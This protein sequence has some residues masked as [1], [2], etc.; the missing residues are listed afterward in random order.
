MSEENTEKM[1]VENQL[2]KLELLPECMA[3]KIMTRIEVTQEG[4]RF[5]VMV[6]A[7]AEGKTLAW[8]NIKIAEFLDLVK[9]ALTQNLN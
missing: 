3:S 8:A 9:L 4:Q 6:L 7:N 1:T 2:V 5:V